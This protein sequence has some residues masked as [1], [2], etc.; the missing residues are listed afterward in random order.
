MAK[1]KILIHPDDTELAPKFTVRNYK[2]ARDSNPPDRTAIADAIR[3]R[4]VD[5]YIEP[6]KAKPRGFTIMAVSCLMIEALESF[7][8]GWESSNGRSKA[9][10]CFFF[11]AFAP[12]KDLRGHAQAFYKHVRCGILHQA[13]TTGGWRIRRDSSPLFDSSNFTINAN[14]FLDALVAV[15]GTFCD[16]LK[17]LPWDSAEWK[18]VRKK[19]EAIV[20]NC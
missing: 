11:D 5:R 14:K 15:L 4:F 17:T 9:A 7:R 18:N 1:G 3:A 13:E 19:M 8:Q 10:F 20:R 16:E 2:R 12:F 6:V